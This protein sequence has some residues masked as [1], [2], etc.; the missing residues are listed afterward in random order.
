MKRNYDERSVLPSKIFMVSGKQGLF[1]LYTASDCN[2]RNTQTLDAS[3]TK[4]VY[5]QIATGASVVKTV[6]LK[7][8]LAYST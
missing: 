7:L 3:M 4:C 5:C 2:N 8:S 1:S 6:F